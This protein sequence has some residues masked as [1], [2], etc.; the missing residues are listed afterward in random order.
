NSDIMLLVLP[1][2]KGSAPNVLP[3]PTRVKPSGANQFFPSLKVDPQTGIIYLGFYD[4]SGGGGASINPLL[5][6]SVD[7]GVSFAV[8]SN[9]SSVPSSPQIQSQIIS[10]NGEGIG[11]GDYIWL[12]ISRST[13]GAV[14]T[15]T[16]NNKQEIFFGG[17]SFG[18]TGGGPLPPA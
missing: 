10:A 2:F 18:S 14:W 7:G 15:D 3:N 4:Q 11:I 16:R 8:P 12:D 1:P 13:L 17:L 5:T 9:L 6:T